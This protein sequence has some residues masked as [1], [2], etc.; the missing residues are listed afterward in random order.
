MSDN[1]KLIQLLISQIEYSGN[2]RMN[3][4]KKLKRIK[5]EFKTMII[6]LETFKRK[7]NVKD[8]HSNFLEDPIKKVGLKWPIVLIIR[9]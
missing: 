6:E 2:F 3:T 8:E 7:T 4:E 5:G 1:I 9:Q